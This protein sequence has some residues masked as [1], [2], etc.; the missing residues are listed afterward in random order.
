[1]LP[2]FHC[3]DGWRVNDYHSACKGTTKNAYTQE[4]RAIIFKNDK[5]QRL[6]SKDNLGSILMS[7]H[8]NS[9]RLLLFAQRNAAHCIGGQKKEVMRR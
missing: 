7:I 4:K 9:M 2:H 3:A 8:V 1:M 5:K 6:N